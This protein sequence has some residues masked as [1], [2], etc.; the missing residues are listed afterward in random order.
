RG[1]DRRPK[2]AAVA[3][4][5]PPPSDPRGLLP[6]EPPPLR[7]RTPDLRRRL[8]E[9]PRAAAGRARQVA[10]GPRDDRHADA[11]DRRRLPARG[12]ALLPAEGTAR[13]RRL[14]DL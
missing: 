12:A 14:A 4:P 1:A 11:R 7:D 8:A 13:S 10:R 2:R 5:R 6:R 3:D 9:R